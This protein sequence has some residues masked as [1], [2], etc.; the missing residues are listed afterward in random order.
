MAKMTGQRNGENGRPWSAGAGTTGL[1]VVDYVLKEL[2]ALD[3]KGQMLLDWAK[4][5]A[6]DETLV[7]KRS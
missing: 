4:W 7:L 2:R 1:V 3:P 5:P 6:A